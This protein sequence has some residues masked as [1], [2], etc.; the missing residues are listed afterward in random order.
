MTVSITGPSAD[1]V[2][3][4]ARVDNFG[5]LAVDDDAVIVEFATSTGA[6]TRNGAELDGVLG[7]TLNP[8]RNVTVTTTADASTYNTT[9]PI[10]ISG[11]DVAGTSIT[12]NV[13]LTNAN[14]GETKT[15]TKVFATVTSVVFP[16]MLTTNGGIRVGVGARVGLRY[17]PFLSSGGF[18][19]AQPY[20]DG[21]PIDVGTVPPI[22]SGGA[23]P[24]GAYDFTG[25]I[26]GT[27]L[28][29]V[30]VEDLS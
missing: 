23:G 5:T 29:A 21:T 10:V 1:T 11:T 20:V 8:P 15:G 24:W 18:P 12:E 17:K 2:T 19:Y 4:A 26:G 14:G 6:D 28:G 13:T 27:E 3:T 9:D 30:Y 7:G 25:A 22:A 16:A